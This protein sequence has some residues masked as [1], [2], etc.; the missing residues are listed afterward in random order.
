[1][2]A[3]GHA[4]CRVNRPKQKRENNP[5]HSSG[6]SRINGLY[7]FAFSEYAFDASGKAAAG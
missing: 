5:M 2:T 1:M 7:A 6:I 3:D 4:G